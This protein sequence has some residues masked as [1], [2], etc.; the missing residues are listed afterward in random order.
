MPS[1]E[2]PELSPAAQPHPEETHPEEAHPEEDRQ[3]STSSTGRV[4]YAIVADMVLILLFAVIGRS[5]HQEGDP[6]LGALATAWPFLSGALLG[7]LV[8]RLWQAPLRVWPHGVCLV[9][10]TVIGGVVLRLL[11]GKTA[12]ISFVIV[13]T[14]VLAVFLLGH[15]LIAGLILRRRAAN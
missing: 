11:T 8:A 9:I 13:A 10:I 15:R 2:S 6:I 12:E 5:S 7:W 14:V 3:R 1:D 4:L